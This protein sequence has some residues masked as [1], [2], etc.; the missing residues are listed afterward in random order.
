MCFDMVAY[1]GIIIPK[2]LMY[3]YVEGM[4]GIVHRRSIHGDLSNPR[5]L[6]GG[7]VS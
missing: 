4:D 6:S 3:A 7:L 5:P 1:Q 2:A